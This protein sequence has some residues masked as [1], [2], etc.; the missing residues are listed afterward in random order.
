MSWLKE[1]LITKEDAKKYFDFEIETEQGI[2]KKEYVAHLSMFP[3]LCIDDVI[4]LF[5]DLDPRDYNKNKKHPRY[6]IIYDAIYGAVEKG[7]IKC[8]YEADINGHIWDNTIRIP[9][10]IAKQWADT[11]GLKWNVPPYKK[12]SN[13]ADDIDEQ[14]I[15]LQTELIDKSQLEEYI[16]QLEFNNFQL[17]DTIV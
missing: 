7:N 5:L 4:S 2:S 10:N 16:S 14:E 17:N 13:K 1:Y 3:D 9:H 15:Q 11:Y 12:F 6:N 8:Y